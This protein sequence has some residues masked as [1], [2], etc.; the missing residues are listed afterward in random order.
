MNKR[1]WFHRISAIIWMLLTI[2]ALIWLK[3]AI[4]FVIIASIYANVKSD[5]A[6]S[7]A[8]DD[9]SVLQELKEVNR[10]LDEVLALWDSEPEGRDIDGSR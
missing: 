3:D 2:P 10:K 8:A 7:E 6:A 1:V 5:W 9:S 4:W